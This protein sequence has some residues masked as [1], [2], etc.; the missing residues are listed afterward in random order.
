MA[1]TLAGHTLRPRT[2][3]RSQWWAPVGVAGLA[4]VGCATLWFADPT[5]PGGILPVCP[6][7]ALFGIDCPGCGGMRMVYSLLHGDVGAAVH[8]NALSIIAVGMMVW[9]YGAWVLGLARKR[10]VRSWQHISWLPKVVLPVVLVWFVVRN[11][12]WAPFQ[13]LHV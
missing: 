1:L 2:S 4:V 11:L 6:T 5:T 8:Y 13:A 10:P 7:K 9:G 12:P 3:A